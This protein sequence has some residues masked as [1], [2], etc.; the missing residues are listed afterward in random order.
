MNSSN[1]NI[2]QAES[3]VRLSTESEIEASKANRRLA[4]ETVKAAIDG[5]NRLAQDKKAHGSS[6]ISPKNS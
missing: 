1:P 6:H 4:D 2:A 3:P 5:L